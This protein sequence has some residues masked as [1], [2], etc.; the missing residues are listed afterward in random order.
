MHVQYFRCF[1]SSNDIMKMGGRGG[2]GLWRLQ[3]V[4]LWFRDAVMV[5]G[6]EIDRR[7]N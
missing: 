2:G 7:M 4:L 3:M 1:F 5:L 6:L